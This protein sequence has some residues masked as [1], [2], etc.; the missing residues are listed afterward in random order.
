MIPVH[1][2][3]HTS[4]RF[5]WQV[6]VIHSHALEKGLTNS[7][8]KKKKDATSCQPCSAQEVWESRALGHIL[9]HWM[10][11]MQEPLKTALITRGKSQ[12]PQQ[13]RDKNERKM[14]WRG[15]GRGE[16]RIVFREETTLI[17]VKTDHSE[18]RLLLP[19]KIY[20]PTNPVFLNWAVS[21]QWAVRHVKGMRTEPEVSLMRSVIRSLWESNLVE[22][23]Q[24]LG[25]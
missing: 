4:T 7:G 5:H 22:A 24:L 15:R 14:L 17:S 1:I 16:I 23:F 10:P 12:P 19:W 11:W 21:Q 6:G 2:G 20:F 18:A 3:A 25:H 13:L 8:R 9:L